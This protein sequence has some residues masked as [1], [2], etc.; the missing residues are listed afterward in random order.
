MINYLSTQGV[1]PWNIE[2]V[3]GGIESNETP[4]IA[5]HKF[6]LA[7]K[8]Q[9][10]LARAMRKIQR[11]S[12]RR[13]LS[14]C[15]LENFQIPG[16]LKDNGKNV[17]NYSWRDKSRS[18][19]RAD[20]E[21]V[22]HTTSLTAKQV[23]G[24]GSLGR[25]VSAPQCNDSEV[26]MSLDVKQAERKRVMRSRSRPEP[27][28]KAVSGYNRQAN[29]VSPIKEDVPAVQET[30]SLVTVENIQLT[31]KV[32]RPWPARDMLSK[33]LNDPRSR[34]TSLFLAR[35]RH[36]SL[37]QSS[38]IEVDYRHRRLNGEEVFGVKGD[39]KDFLEPNAK[40]LYEADLTNNNSCDKKTFVEN[41][42]HFFNNLNGRIY[43]NGFAMAI[44]GSLNN[45]M[46]LKSMNMDPPS[47]TFDVGGLSN[48]SATLCST[49]FSLNGFMEDDDIAARTFTIR[50]KTP[51]DMRKLNVVHPPNSLEVT[52][53]FPTMPESGIPVAIK[54]FKD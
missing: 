46:K 4:L 38:F 50:G 1:I 18:R 23:E 47:M 52:I 5:R 44:D 13:C 33:I 49:R 7:I 48:V 43:L 31:K 25:L 19:P 24:L 41:A 29:S 2:L 9:R 11:N 39:F 30:P 36:N 51:Q 27:S 34:P 15:M 12:G 54:D 26:I 14:P 35:F 22:Q 37:E 53:I 3:P 40:L 28:A 10:Q 21:R 42:P 20:E 8:R 32:K 16:S 45:R 6:K 17:Y